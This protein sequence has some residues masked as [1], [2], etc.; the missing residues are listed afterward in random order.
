[1]Q[2]SQHQPSTSH[3][4][5]TLRE[6]FYQRT[7]LCL[8]LGVVFFSLFSVLD[9][10]YTNEDFKLFLL[11]RMVYVTFLLCCVNAL[12]FEP[13][14]PFA[15]H[16]MIL[17]MLMGSFAISL[18]TIRL[19]GFY[20]NYYIGI[21]LM[22]AGGLSGLPLQAAQATFI[23]LFMYFIY[24]ATVLLGTGNTDN[25]HL[26]Y[27]MNNSFFF[28]SIVAVAAVQ[29]YD[30]M[31]NL[32]KEDRA[33]RSLNRLRDKL[34]AHTNGL[35][36]T[37]QRRLADLEETNLR[38]Q[39]LYHNIQDLIVLVEQNGTI[40]RVNR[41]SKKVLGYPP[42]QLYLTDIRDLFHS[43]A[44]GDEWFEELHDQ[45]DKGSPVQ[46]V[47]LILKKKA[48]KTIEVEVNASK[49]E[50]DNTLFFQLILR[51]ISSTK[52]IERKLLDSQRL[53]GTS[54]QAAIFGLAKLAECR[55][56]D[57]G[58]HLNR[59]RTYSKILAE[60][61]AKKAPFSDAI[62]KT[63]VED[64]YYS[65]V[66]HDIGKV[67]IPDSILLKP[68]KLTNQ[69]FEQMKQ[70]TVFGSDVLIAAEKNLE[71]L[72]FLYTGQEIA[73]SHHERWDANGYPDN[74]AEEEIP[75][76][77]RILSVADVY[78]ALTSARV[79]KPSFSHEDSMEIIVDQRGKQFD[80]RIVDAFLQ[81]EHLFKETR[82]K[83]VLQQP[84]SQNE[85]DV[86]LH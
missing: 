83:L 63:F 43:E 72:S 80:P 13:V 59:I 14:K 27:G 30:D 32:I 50:M 65:S 76:A 62:T 3:F 46:G 67:G 1:M 82:I 60:E 37:I 21:L 17:A 49:V 28:L 78:D 54:R 69:E 38:Y 55:D 4:Q 40:H 79:Y 52:S 11:Y 77:A 29:S 56:N 81:N 75:L 58:A 26:I 42:E 73:R 25:S 20:S 86:K 66:L 2:S 10:L 84:E 15:P 9:F 7:L 23:G 19:G 68:G 74:L 61:L 16:I 71:S 5:T 64:L 22:L 12:R 41:H 36:E 48:R 57:T 70:H 31:E 85:T 24:M 44:S 53:I 33:K 18:M 34:S 47:Q 39:D 6:L 35:E 45:V 8:W 51:D